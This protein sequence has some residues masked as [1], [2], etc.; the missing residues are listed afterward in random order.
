MNKTFTKLTRCSWPGFLL[1]FLLAAAC[2]LAGCS[3]QAAPTF[4]PLPP[5]DSPAPSA[6]PTEA[7]TQTPYVVTATD[8]GD[9]IA[10]AAAG[11]FILS[12]AD[13][14]HYHLF[15][16]SP[17]SLPLT[18]L[19]QDAWDDITPSL[20]PD[21]TRVAY[22]SNRNGY[23]DLYLLDLKTG[24]TTRLTDTPEYDA[25]PSWSPD[26]AWL[27]YESY[28]GGYLQIFIRPSSDSSQSAIRLTQEAATDSSPA[29]VPGQGRQIAF[30]SDRS[31]EN[32]IWIAD[33]DK[34]GDDRFYNVSHDNGTFESHPA[35]S[36]DGSRLAW[37][38][39][40]PDNGLTGIYVWDRSKPD[41]PGRWVGSGDW[42]V[43]QDAGHFATRLSTPNQT[44]LT[45]Y[46]SPHGELILPP[47]LLPAPVHGLSYGT[48][49]LPFPGAFQAAAERTPKPLY[50][51]ALNP[52][53]NVPAG[54]AWVVTLKGVQ[55]PYP[56]LHDLVD[57]S[58]QGLRSSL[59]AAIGWDALASL[60]NAFVPLT[61]PPDPGLG[62]DWLYTGR[63]FT[64]NSSQVGANWM[65]VV[66]EDFGQQTYWRVFLRTLAQDGS[67][68]E[69]LSQLPWDFSARSG[70]PQAYDQGGRLMRSMPAGYWFDLT[71]LAIQYGWERLPALTDWRMYFNGA[72]FN[73]FAMTQGL[74]WRTAMLE[75]YPPDVLVT[76]TVVIPPTRTPTRTPWWYQTPTPTRTPTFK[77]TNTP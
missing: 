19:T 7:P 72:R 50:T 15:A 31:G 40:D 34:V 65:A 29:W 66:R 25:A 54:R 71:A 77:P 45:G 36:P 12:L 47:V 28:I 61:T 23:W 3:P 30:V 53:S 42:P 58:F 56:E 10:A 18:R 27:A 9:P 46:A 13:S 67:Q 43:W 35:W 55:A 17:Q 33:L 39:T 57:E 48:I 21:G 70:D 75:L 41:T 64:L 74:D 22:A 16:Y 44:F 52:P 68:G 4:T 6:T 51:P 60:E 37:S 62:E 11:V 38:A 26:G 32:E 14:G 1:T 73:E 2:L 76:P 49:S 63:A 24:Q 69:P 20:S 8:Q 59:A 5:T